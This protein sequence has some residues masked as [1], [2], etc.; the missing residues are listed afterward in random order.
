MLEFGSLFD[1]ITNKIYNNATYRNIFTNTIYCA[2]LITVIIMLLISAMYPYKRN[3]PT[4]VVMK[5]GIYIFIATVACLF[6]FKSFI[7]NK[8]ESQMRNDKKDS[9]F[10]NM[11]INDVT[12]GGDVVA[13]VPNIV[14]EE[15]KPDPPKFDA[16]ASIEDMLDSL[17]NSI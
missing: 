1:G 6:V 15:A 9:I 17:E 2:L 3:T 14:A 7:K 12:R 4:W 13:V 5:L 11:D 8:Y 10:K 16:D